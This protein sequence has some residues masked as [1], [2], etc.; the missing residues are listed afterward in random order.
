MLNVAD[1]GIGNK[2]IK[3]L[4]QVKFINLTYLNIENNNLTSKCLPSLKR[5]LSKDSTLLDLRLGKNQIEDDCIVE[6]SSSDYKSW[7]ML[8]RLD[9]DSNPISEIGL[10]ALFES[11]VNNNQLEHLNV[12]DC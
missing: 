1:N 8:M 3:L 7:S 6:M 4:S 12:E 2:G 9:L 10:N 5:I 11:L